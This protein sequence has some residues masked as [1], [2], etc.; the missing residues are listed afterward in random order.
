MLLETLEL[1]EFSHDPK[2]F[3]FKHPTQQFNVYSSF[4]AT[5]VRN[6]HWHHRQQTMNDLPV[7]HGDFFEAYSKK[8]SR[9]NMMLA[10]GVIMVGI[11]SVVVSI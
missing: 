2:L 7:P 8:Q 9:Y 6:Y 4:S 1:P 11:S 10:A 5:L 3:K